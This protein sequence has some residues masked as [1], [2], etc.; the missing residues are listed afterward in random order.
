[1]TQYDNTNRGILFPNDKKGNEKAPAHKGK[2]DVEG[3]EYEIAAW[4]KEGRKGEFLSLSI[5]KK[6]EYSKKVS[7][8]HNTS[9]DIDDD[10][11]PF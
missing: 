7:E 2:L 11:I 6:G 4:V 3:V 8:T 9:A 10:S 5:K 1:M